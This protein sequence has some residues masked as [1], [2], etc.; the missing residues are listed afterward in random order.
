MTA[1]VQ[2]RVD[3]QRRTNPQPATV[4][5]VVPFRL[6]QGIG[7]QHRTLPEKGEA[8]GLPQI[9]RPAPKLEDGAPVSV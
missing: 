8:F 6:Q 1:S 2:I 3:A 7:S 4:R 5:R 9:V